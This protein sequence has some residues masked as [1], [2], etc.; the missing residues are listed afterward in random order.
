MIALLRDG[1]QDQEVLLME[2]TVRTDDPASGQV[3][4]PGGHVDPADK[5]LRDTAL[6]ELQEE[7]G[8]SAFDLVETP[9][10]VG[11]KSAPRFGLQVGVFASALAPTAPGQFHPS[12]R[13]VADI[14]WLPLGALSQRTS[15]LRET[16]LGPA[17]VEAVVHHSHVV[18]GLTLRILLEAFS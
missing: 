1:Q 14:F 16:R 8:L 10:F 5:T 12:P 18:W 11:V 17:Q 15:V 6:R 4:L 2:R 13:E 3:S 9:R 7:I